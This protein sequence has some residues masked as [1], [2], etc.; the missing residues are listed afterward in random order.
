M[1]V[2]SSFQNDLKDNTGGVAKVH[3]RELMMMMMLMITQTILQNKFALTCFI[4]EPK[5]CWQ[6]KQQ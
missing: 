2:M 4:D 3:N 6:S 5:G 1:S